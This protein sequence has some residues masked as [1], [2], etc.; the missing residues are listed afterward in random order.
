MGDEVTGRSGRR[1]DQRGAGQ[2]LGAGVIAIANPAASR[3]GKDTPP[4]RARRSRHPNDATCRPD[5]PADALAVAEQHM[6]SISAD[7]QLDP[8]VRQTLGGEQVVYGQQHYRGLTIFPHSLVIQVAADGDLTTTGDPLISVGE[9]DVVPELR[10]EDAVGAAYRHLRAGTAEDCHTPHEPRFGTG[11]YR[12]RVLSA[13][14]MTSRPTVLSAGPFDAPVQANL[15]VCRGTAQ[16]A[17]AWLVS[18][19]VKQVADFTLAIRASGAR[20]GEVLYCAAEAA[21]ACSAN[22][23]LFSPDEPP[24]VRIDFPRPVTDYPPGIRPATPFR[25]WLDSDQTAGN[26]VR[27]KFGNKDRFVRA[28]PGPTGLHFATPPKSD[29]EKVVNAFFLCNFMHDFLSLVG[30]GE[31]DSNFQQKNFT[32]AG[33][34]GDRLIVNVVSVAQGNANMRAQN[35]GVPAELTLGMWKNDNPASVANP[36]ALDAEVVIHEYVH[37]VSQRLVGGPLKK[38]AL[39][40][41]QSLALGEA[42]SDYF[43]ITIQNYYRSPRPPRYTF[44][45]YASRKAGGVRPQPYDAFTAHFG[46]LGTPPYHEQHGAGSIFAAALIKMHD[47]LVALPGAALGPET[48]WRLVVA[49]LKKL[50][51]NP[52]FLEARDALLQSVAGLSSP[53]AVAIERVIRTAFARFGMGRN[54]RCKNTSFKD[55]AADFST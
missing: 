4:E 3:S 23:Y 54:A 17:L 14:P 52:T 43:A 11:R 6:R 19:V 21:S 35:D 55:I 25:D 49:S 34:G 24:A 7:V 42:W 2:P 5:P 50:K 16:P 27:M 53:H 47:D 10:V 28:V 12:P 15:V 13:F 32:G 38:S 30:F 33:K 46:Q 51:A 44:A 29:D 8:H 31:A 18:L 37:G 1:R 26:N 22:V 41:K 45:A 48:G 40:E 20:A 36:T 9:L 39:V